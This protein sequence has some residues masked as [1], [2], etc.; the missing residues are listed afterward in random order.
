MFPL[1]ALSRSPR[2]RSLYG[3]SGREDFRKIGMA[4]AEAQ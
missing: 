2:G 4:H 3:G 1:C